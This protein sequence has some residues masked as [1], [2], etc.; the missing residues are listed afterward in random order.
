[1]A[2]TNN[3][4]TSTISMY[5]T[6]K[7]VLYAANSV[8]NTRK[9]ENIRSNPRFSPWSFPPLRTKKLP[10][11]SMLLTHK[12]SSRN[13]G[14]RSWYSSLHSKTVKGKGISTPKYLGVLLITAAT[15]ERE[16]ISRK[17]TLRH[18]SLKQVFTTLLN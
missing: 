10:I 5:L 7:K 4:G 9:E 1:M 3:S 6:M 13:P 2:A 16:Q 18:P 17:K 14:T 12:S 8:K 11:N 15:I